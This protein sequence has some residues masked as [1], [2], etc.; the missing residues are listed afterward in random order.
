MLGAFIFWLV[1]L[2]VIHL[3]LG[4]VAMAM[5]FVLMLLTIAIFPD[6]YVGL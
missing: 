5:A 4:Q 2:V 6:L 3:L 1:L